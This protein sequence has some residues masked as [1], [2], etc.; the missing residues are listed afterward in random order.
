MFDDFIMISL[1]VCMCTCNL[2]TPGYFHEKRTPLCGTFPNDRNY[3][4]GIFPAIDDTTL[5]CA[6]LH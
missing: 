6:K 3:T 4:F 5:H 2:Y 1:D